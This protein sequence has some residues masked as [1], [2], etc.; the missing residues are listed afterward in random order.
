MK[1]QTIAAKWTAK[2]K[3]T[4]PSGKYTVI[5]RAEEGFVACCPT[6]RTELGKVSDGPLTEENMGWTVKQ[7]RAGIWKYLSVR[8]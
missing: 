5:F 8:V 6:L 7:A 4:Y 1:D 3:N 2:L